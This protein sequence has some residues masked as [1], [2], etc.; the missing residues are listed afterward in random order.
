[1][2]TS[3]MLLDVVAWHTTLS[4]FCIIQMQVEIIRVVGPGSFVSQRVY[5]RDII[6]EYLKTLCETL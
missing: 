4:G 1:M 2:N 5:I 3:T 6:T